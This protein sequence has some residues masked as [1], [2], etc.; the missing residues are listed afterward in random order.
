MLES[1]DGEMAKKNFAKN[2]WKIVYTIFKW[3]N[4]KKKNVSIYCID[5]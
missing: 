4:C 3:V 2:I 5:Y 1:M